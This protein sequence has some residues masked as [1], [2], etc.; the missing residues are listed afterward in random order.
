MINYAD[1]SNERI[2]RVYNKDLVEYKEI[3]LN[4]KKQGGNPRYRLCLHDSPENDLH[5]MVI[6][7]SKED[8][9][10][11]HKHNTGTESHFIIKG[12]IL[13]VFFDEKGNVIQ[14]V[15]LGK[16]EEDCLGYRINSN[17]YHMLIPLSDTAF[18]HE[19]KKGPFTSENNVYAEW[20]PENYDK[21]F[22][23]EVSKHQ[24]GLVSIFHCRCL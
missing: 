16:Q 22:L 1:F 10:R 9:F 8:Y 24:F 18:F 13:A 17:T 2:T 5:E 12:R 11:P 14:H 23:G 21:K 20:S 19:T 6:C 3:A 7:V 15:I 4:N